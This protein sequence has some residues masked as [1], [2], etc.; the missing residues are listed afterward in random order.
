MS[1]SV[2]ESVE[3]IA[4]LK[5][6][7]SEK[8]NAF[9]YDSWRDFSLNLDKALK[10]RGLVITGEGKAFSAGDDIYAMYRLESYREA[11]KFFD[12]A[13]NVLEK[14]MHYPYP[15]VA[16]VNGL[17]VGGGAEILL[18]VDYVISVKDAWFWFP[19]ARIGLYPPILISLGAFLFGIKKVKRLA[20][21]MPRLSIE[22]ALDLG[23]VDEVVENKDKLLE[24]AVNKVRELNSIP[25]SSYMYIRNILANIVLP[26]LKQSIDTLARAVVTE[27]AKK[28]MELFIKSKEK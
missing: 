6:T 26:H 11:K 10:Y 21:E 23:I 15:I 14:M 28:W 8:L 13:Y 7:R 24:T 22:E 16:A 4:V 9:D 18:G 1:R 2:L 20:I 27:E 17:A 12:M 25:S 19:E 3:D 5:F